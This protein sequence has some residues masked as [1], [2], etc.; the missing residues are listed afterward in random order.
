[1]EDPLLTTQEVANELRLNIHTVYRLIRR[2]ELA[3]VDAG[4]RT[5]RVK[6]SA[7]DKYKAEREVPKCN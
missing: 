1:M 6:R 7:L 4:Y 5:K 3:H 2:G